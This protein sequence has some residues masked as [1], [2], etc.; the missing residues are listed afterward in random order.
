MSEPKAPP[1][2]ANTERG[3]E[4][5]GRVPPGEGLNTRPVGATQQQ[6]RK[7]EGRDSRRQQEGHLPVSTSCVWAASC[8]WW[9]HN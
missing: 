2:A 6:Q 4:G 8:W 5:V 7:D 9:F 1:D 3:E